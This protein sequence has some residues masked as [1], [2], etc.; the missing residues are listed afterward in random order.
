MSGRYRH[1]PVARAGDRIGSG[2][3]ACTGR[4]LHPAAARVL[5]PA[6][7]AVGPD[8]A[9]LLFLAEHAA[10]GRAVGDVRMQLVVEVAAVKLHSILALYARIG[11]GGNV[12]ISCVGGKT[13]YQK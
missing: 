11:I 5:V 7:W 13:K 12:F 10:R 4:P 2:L 6:G 9:L 1:G 8:L 3:P